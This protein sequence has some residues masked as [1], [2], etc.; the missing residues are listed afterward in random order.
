[1]TQ[2]RKVLYTFFKCHWLDWK[3]F[4]MVM[5]LFSNYNL[6]KVQMETLRFVWCDKGCSYE[7]ISSNKAI[8]FIFTV[9]TDCKAQ[10]RTKSNKKSY[11]I[12]VQ[13]TFKMV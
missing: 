9:T 5:W 6:T 12:F 8:I 2:V 1:M 4:V 11:D 7:S 3:G 13:G 10:K